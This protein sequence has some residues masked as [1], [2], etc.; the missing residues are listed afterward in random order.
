MVDLSKV[1]V[2][3]LSVADVIRY[4]Q[5]FINALKNISKDQEFE[6]TELTDK[7]RNRGIGIY[8]KDGVKHKIYQVLFMYRSK[9]AKE[10]PKPVAIMS[11][12]EQDLMALKDII[13]GCNRFVFANWDTV[14]I[15]LN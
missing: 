15:Y 12:E 3:G 11:M 10:V 2:E 14:Y 13:H 4:H 6:E 9:N 7:L 5:I 8:T 1:M